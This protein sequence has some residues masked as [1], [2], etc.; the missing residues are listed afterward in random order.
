MKKLIKFN[1][2]RLKKDRL[3]YV[4]IVSIIFLS[5]LS[6][7]QDVVQ[8]NI[9]SGYEGFIKSYSDIF[10][11]F[12]IAIYCGYFIGNDFSSKIIQRQ[13][14]SGAS[15]KDIVISKFVVFIFAT[16]AIVNLYPLIVGVL[17]SFKYGFFSSDVE[18]FNIAQCIRI[19]V[20]SNLCFISTAS[21]YFLF[22]FV[23]QS[24]GKTIGISMAFPVIISMLQGVVQ[25]ESIKK[26][27]QL[28]PLTQIKN[29]IINQ[30]FVEGTLI[31]TIISILT[32]I[33]MTI[34]SVSIFKKSDI[35]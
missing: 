19:I 4:L 29:I 8:K 14:T 22:G 35:N 34:M 15:R 33:T 25:I 28:F 5:I 21:I 23:T 18:I 6:G 9:T 2:E 7:F 24:L 26:I 27:F 10:M 16:I 13:I 17:G 11:S 20:I 30:N 31:P 1:T 3:F 12:F 32:L